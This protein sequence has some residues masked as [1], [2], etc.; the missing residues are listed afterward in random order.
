MD[1]S[2]DTEQRLREYL[3]RATVDLRQAR[4]RLAEA[5]DRAGEPI[6]IVGMACR[7][8]GGVRSPEDL[9]RL[10]AAGGDATSEFPT[11][12]GW[13]PDLH[14]PDPDRAGHTYTTRGGFLDDV[15]RFDAE[16]FGISPREALAMDP[17]QRQLLEVSW[18]A[19]ERA[20]IDPLSLRGTPTG[21][22]A[23]AMVQDYAS[24][25]AVPP[26]GF[27]GYLGNGNSGAMASGRVA[28]TLGLEGPAVTLDTACSSSLVAVHLAAQALRQGEC[29]L[30]LT[31]G[32]TVMSTPALF[33]EF[34]RQRGLAPDGRCKPFSAGADGTGWAEGVGVLVLER[35]SEARRHGRR[36]LAVVRGSAVNSDGA[37]SGLTAPNGPSQQRVI[38][39]ALTVAG[40]SPSDVDVVE[41]H[42]T[43][44]TLGD[45]IE[46]QALLATYGQDRDRPLLLG[47]V[48]ANL[49]HTQ[50]AAG[51]AGIIK[52][53]MAMRHGVVPPT[54]HL[55]EPTPRVDWSEGAVSLVTEALPWP[56]RDAP[57]RAGVSAFGASGTNAHLVLEQAPPADALDPPAGAAV[58]PWPLSGHTPEALRAQAAGLAGVTADPAEI[59]LALATAR[60]ALE[61]R[62][63]LVAGPDQR[64]NALAALAD[65]LPHPDV[66]TGQAPGDPRE[67]VFVFPGQGSQWVGM[68]VDLLD[69]PVFAAR[70]DECATALSSYVDWDL[71]EV[72]R[73]ESALARVDVVQP[74]LWAVMVSLAAVWRHHGVKPAAVVGHSQGEIAAACVAG[75]LSLEDGA[76]V[77]ALR[78][79][80]LARIAGR[81]GMVSV[82]LPVGEVDLSGGLS[83]AA[84]NGPG[85]TVVSGPPAALAAVLDRYERA[86]RVPVDYASHSVQVA[87]LREEL[88]TALA[89]V[90]PRPGQIPFH[91]TVTGARESRLDAEYWYRNLRETVRFADVT[92]ELAAH[93][94]AFVEV[95]PHPVLTVGLQETVD[96]A[97][98]DAVVLGTLRRDEPG[99]RRLLASFAEA[100]TR[101]VPVDWRPAFSGARPA[102]LPTYPFGGDRY[103]LTEGPARGVLDR[104]EDLADGGL[105]LSGTLTH[106]THP[107]LPDHAVD[108]TVL[109]P[110]TGMLELAAAA[111]DRVG[112]PRVEE[113]AL[114]APLPVPAEA[115]VTL[116]VTVGGADDAGRRSLR[117]HARPSPDDPWTRHATGTLAPQAGAPAPAPAEWPP[118][119]AEPV[120]LDGLYERLADGGLGYGPAFRGLR[121]AWRHDDWVLA[122]VALPDGL[123]P[124]GFLLHPALVDA[125]LQAVGLGG[126]LDQPDV[127]L[128]P[129]AI[130]GAAVHATGATALR[131]MVTAAGR[132]AVRLAL[133]DTAGRAVAT[134]DSLVLR[135]MPRTTAAWR[136][137]LY[138]VDW[139]PAAPGSGEVPPHEVVECGS[140]H[141]ALTLLR[142]RLADPDATGPLVVLT[143]GAVAARPA[144]LPDLAAAAVW[145]LVRSAQTENPGR[146]VLVDLEAGTDPAEPVARV[147][148]ADEPQVAVRDG[149]MFVP[150]LSRARDL[151]VVEPG[152]RLAAGAGGSLDDLHLVPSGEVEP[153]PGQVRLDVRA[154][155][156]NFRDVLIALDLYPGEPVLGA[157][158]AG[159]VTAVGQGVVDLAPGDRVFGLVPG[160]FARSAVVD[161]RLLAR[162][163]RDWTFAEAASVPVVFLSAYYALRD[164]ADLRAGETVLVHAA[165]GGVGMAATQLAR[166]LG[167]HVLGTASPAKWAATGLDETC[168]ASSREP[169][170]AD[171]FRGLVGERGVDVVLNSLT[172][173]F[174]DESL[175]LLAA[176]GR[177]VELGRT[178]LRDPADLPDVRYRAFELFEA[179]PDRIAEMLTELL[180]LFERGVL[181]PLP[182]RTWD[183]GRGREALRHL[184]QGENVGK[185]VLTVPAPLDPDGTVLVTGGTGTLGGLLARHLV[186]AHGC[187]HLLLT[188]L[189]GR[190]GTDLAGE[191]TALGARVR[192]RRCDV[193]DRDAL[194]ALVASVPAEHPLTAVVHTAG[195][196]DDGVLET[197]TPAHLDRV[198]A[199]KA[200][201]AEHLAELTRDHDLAAFVLFSSAAATMG[202]A[203]QGNYAAANAVLDALALRLRAAGRPATAVAWGLWEP[204]S[205]MT[206]GLDATDRERMRRAGAAPLSTADGM[207]LFD[208][209]LAVAEP[210]LVATRIDLSAVRARAAT[211]GVPAL[212][213]GLVPVRGERRT[214]GSATGGL[215]ALPPAELA[216]ALTDLVRTHVAATLGHG[217]PD[218][219]P[220]RK[221][222]REQGF[223]SLTA[224]ELRNR[225]GAATG[226][227]LPATLVFDHPT[228]T[229]L[230][231]HLT[232]ELTGAAADAGAPTPA[233]AADDD[234]IAIV[235]LSCRFPGGVGTP[236]EL[237]RLLAD[238]GDAIGPFPTDRGW[239]PDPRATV[240]AGGFLPD[241]ALFDAGFFGIAPREA[242][243]SDPQQRL[244]LEAS[245]E[246]LER[247]GID[248]ATLR[249]TRTGVYV[250]AAY[251]DYG[252]GMFDAEEDL[253]GY[254][255]TGN[256]G[257]VVSGRISYTFGF[258]GPSVTVD[259]ACSSSL[260]ALH[261]AVRALRAGECSLA[262]AGG[263]TVMATPNSFV[264]FGRQGGMAPDGRCKAF[265]AAADGF[266]AAE[267]LGLVLVERLSDARANGHPVLALVRGSAVNSDGASNGLTAPNGPSQRRVIQL[268]LADA[269]L[270]PSD[271]DAVEAHGTGTTLGDPIEAGALL[272]TYGTDRER[273][274]WLGSVK[275]N[276]G[277]S[278]FA[279]GVAGVLKVVLALRNGLL[280]RT[281]HV[282]EPSPHVDWSAGE[283]RLLTAPVPWPAGERPRRAGVSSF[284]IS[285]T[286]AHVLLEQA[287]ADPPADPPTAQAG[288]PV[289][290][291]FSAATPAALRE[292]A[293]R[294]ADHVEADEGLGPA[295]VGHSLVSTRAALPHRAAVVA[296]DR[297]GLL[298]GLRSFAADG[299]GALAGVAGADADRV[300]F[301]FAGQGGQWPGMAADL[302]ATSPAFAAEFDACA[303]AI[304]ALVDFSPLAVLRGEPG[305][306][307]LDRIEVLQPVLFAV[308]VSLA[309]LWRAHG[310]EPAAVVGQSQGEVAA[311]YVAGALSLRDAVAV[312]VLRSR[313]FAEELV[314]RGAIASVL[315][316][317]EQV[318]ERIVPWAGRV[319]V[320]GTSGPRSATVS[321]E[322]DALAEL[323]AACTADGIRARVLPATVA[324]HGAQVDPL[325]ERLLASLA[326]VRPRPESIPFYSTVTGD[327]VDPAELDAGYWFRN[328]REPVNLDAAVR[329]LIRD[330][331]R[332]FVEP[333]PHPAATLSVEQI[334]EDARSGTDDHAVRAVATLHRD[335]P[336]PERFAAALAQAYAHGVPVEWSAV[337]P[338]ARRVPLPTYPFQRRRYWVVP[339]RGTG[340]LRAA[341]LAEAAHPLLSAAAGRA[342][343][344]L[345]LTGRLGERDWLAGER[346]HRTLVVP[347]AVLLDL[348]L[349]A[350][351]RV[352]CQVAEL[353]VGE[354][355]VHR[356]EPVVEV[357]VGAPGEDGSRRLTVHTR[358]DDEP[359]TCHA[360]AVLTPEGPLAA[361]APAQWP[362]TGARPVDV[363]AHYA[364]LAAAGV[365]HGP[366]FRALRAAWAHDGET[367]AELRL[368]DD[369]PAGAFALHP[370]LLDAVLHALPADPARTPAAWRGVGVH[371]GEAGGVLRV[372]L[373]PAPDGTVAVAVTDTAGSPVLTVEAVTTAE[374]AV[375]RLRAAGLRDQLVVPELVPAPPA[376][377]VSDWLLVGDAPA[378][379]PRVGGASGSAAVVLAVAAPDEVPVLLCE[380]EESRLVVVTE[381][382]ARGLVLAA[383]AERPGRVQLLDL[384][385]SPASA[386]ALPAALASTEPHLVLRDGAVLVPRLTRPAL[387]DPRPVAAALVTGG[388][389]A[390]RLA[391]HLAARDED[392]DG[393]V[394][395]VADE[396]GEDD[397]LTAARAEV[398]A[399]DNAAERATG[400]L[401]LCGP[402]GPGAAASA[403]RA[404]F[405]RIAER[406]HAAGL[407]T[408][409]LTVDRE[410]DEDLG[411]LLDLALTAGAPTVACLAHEPPAP[412]ESRADDLP[413]AARLAALAEPDRFALVL[414]LVRARA[415]GVLGHD[416]ATELDDSRALRE[417]GFD[418]MSAVV[419]RDR[420]NRATGLRLPATTAF[421]HP[422]VRAL[423]AHLLRE[424]LG[425]PEEH[426][427]AAAAART[428][429]PIAIVAMACRFPGGVRAPE[430]LW[431][432]VAS[433]TDAITPFPTDRGWD[434]EAVY[435]PEPGRP[436]RTYVRSGGFLDEVAGFDAEFFG[437][438]PREAVAMDPQQR[439]LLQSAWEVF[440]RAGLDPTALRGEQVGVFAGTS[441]QDYTGALLAAGAED[442]EA[443]GEDGT[444][445]VITG[446][447]ASVL[448]GRLAYAF[449][450]EGPAVT[451][452][453]A[454]S[455]SLVAVH[456]AAQS[457]R[458]GECSLAVAGAA[459]VMATPAAFVAFSRQ[460]GLAPDG[461]CKAFSAAADG[462]AWAEG[463]GTLL[464]ERLSDARANGHPVLAVLRGSAVNSDGASNG[465]AAPNGRAQQRVIHTALAVAGL[466]PSDVDAVEAHGTGTRL[467][468]PIEATALLA[469][470]G[471]ERDRPLWL[472]SVKSNI[473]HT[474]GVSGIAGVVKTVLS[475]RHGLLPRTLHVDEPTPQVDWSAGAVRLLTED[476]PWP[477]NGRP[478]RAGVSSFGV[479]GT[480]AHVVLEEVDQPLP[481]PVEPGPGPVAWPLSA[482]TPD[483]LAATAEALLS[484]VDGLR[485]ADVAHTLTAG[486][487]VFGTRAVV[488]GADPAGLAALAAGEPHPAVVRGTA[489]RPGPL[490]VLFAG[491]GAQRVG[492]GRGLYSAFGAFA[493]AFD[494]LCDELSGHLGTS[495]R[496]AVFDGP[497]EALRGTALAQAALFA[498]EAATAELLRSFGVRPDYLLGHS[499]GE[500]AAVHAAG[501]LSTEDACALVAARGRL[502]AAL[503]AG[504]AMLAVQATETE[505]VDSINGH[506]VS[507]AAVN[508]PESVV[509]SGDVVGVAALAEQWRARSRRTRLLEVSHAFHSA[510]VEP[511]L[512]ELAEVAAGLT[513]HEPLV[514]IVSTLTGRLAGPELTS[515]GYWP[516]QARSPVRFLDA[517]RTLVG[518]GVRTFL[519]A[520]PDGTLAAAAREAVGPEGGGE[521]VPCLR[522]DRPEPEALTAALARLHVTGRAVDWA[523]FHAPHRPR[524]VDLPTYPF[525]TR[526]F[527]LRVA[528]GAPAER[529]TGGDLLS[530]VR[531]EAA[532]VL[533][534]GSRADVPAD[535]G[536][537]ELGFD[538]LT[539]AELTSRLAAAVGRPVPTV[540]VF[541]HPTP[542][543]LAEHLGALADERDEPASGPEPTV[544]GPFQAMFTRA[545]ESSRTGEFMDFLD[546]ASR[547]RTEF[548]DPAGVGAEPVTITSGPA[549]RTALVCLPGFIGMPGPQQ[550]TR[551]AAP[552]RA[553]REVTVLRHPG[554]APGE[555]VP[556]DPGVLIRLHAEWIER[557]H[558]D[559]PFALVGLSSGGLVAQAVA[560]HLERA[561]VRPEGVVL[562]D[563]FGP[564]LDH[565]VDVLLPEFAVRL[566]D[567]HVAMGYGAADDWL[568]AMGRYVGFDWRVE[569]LTT[570]VLFLRASEPM[571]EWTHEGDWR[572]SWPGARSV[573][574]VPGDHFSMMGDYAEHT[575]AAV[576][577]WLG[578]DVG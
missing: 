547:F 255:V 203:G 87:E 166:H 295:D 150:R 178:D 327:R 353:T 176:G 531:A 355:L 38:R 479:S 215:A 280:P 37:S 389:R 577:R 500:L 135:P 132:D 180:A 490:A 184:R 541:D 138:R 453:T 513:F 393:V 13:D 474:Q 133:F 171:A 457:L 533:G 391:E 335:E 77:V 488:V 204:R 528:E 169:G 523:A 27:E 551:F 511:V 194:A 75:V 298:A 63:V 542:A 79:R 450:F 84:V 471:A 512:T 155:G 322:Q 354:P 362:P 461:R 396:P 228:P 466:Q 239:D 165:A 300:V 156:L 400:Q 418:S 463:V 555:P 238:G 44:T 211:D 553:E 247:A 372:R 467:G 436:G 366:A 505:V 250:G 214:A 220:D 54:P 383:A 494:E 252:T 148:A 12:R 205:G 56:E 568:T 66:V 129:F 241:A 217:S 517:V 124:E 522:A 394:V 574:D 253:T 114:L 147:L 409:S 222:F 339:G 411:P 197:L 112:C 190:D 348:A 364:A 115:T 535:R 131:V 407:P 74:A 196:L 260:V 370:V 110:G 359:W 182:L 236:E 51:V 144:E 170:F 414:D 192:V 388:T 67:A 367:Y 149:A 14:D 23:G 470:Y 91:S 440:E 123:S 282:D 572:T 384:D 550:F 510:A 284:G 232:A 447:S 345:L 47:A 105:L 137:A 475:M 381:D 186:T 283:V 251:N 287:P 307:G 419:L 442:A 52:L 540:A 102:D 122:E 108:G 434:V 333:S 65:G 242:L 430:D 261:L 227:R 439:L 28:Y 57:R 98:A 378:L 316:P 233:R 357:S 552:F 382:P 405:D 395:H 456:L 257:S 350:A 303:D 377:P 266:G 387:G 446:G 187:R 481:P 154:A 564:H 210:T 539:A 302:Y 42:G 145:G 351:H 3:K 534:H 128:L 506:A 420:L 334:A 429:E 545:I 508:G 64:A 437:I 469:T 285:G 81:G 301:V 363:A 33:L 397:P 536:F 524:H 473:G 235:A 356:G 193:S 11:D 175:R 245:W 515:P 82:P 92:T 226:L 375:A 221:P 113:L 380:H 212:L 29:G 321:G 454:C 277:H 565:L 571:I 118:A 30:A 288:G 246:L 451:V 304:A 365:E 271:V 141:H 557:H 309:A 299:S 140:V 549:D 478:R 562:L 161:R 325:R 273:P 55:T 275:S 315:L 26:E 83:V 399:A 570:P 368:P 263:V 485:P 219:V 567:A 294:L 578:K 406:R 201:A 256:S 340:D 60:A 172:G 97:G 532:A 174:V 369:A 390:A 344:G 229:A 527:W 259:T 267:G 6:A 183:L 189:S 424:L 546:A 520:G 314:G 93:G 413:L 376:P 293:A 134:V 160:A 495:L 106:R 111:G 563:T 206:A 18:E 422:T 558:G 88:L 575:A 458:S 185:V 49:G 497:A 100:H 218:A 104:V 324:S 319:D 401:V 90:S 86:R 331:H 269:G 320:A 507:L 237:W 281:L 151:L 125:A 70:F 347:A 62:A 426:T 168:L 36:V 415:A 89:P 342:D 279:A 202:S 412:P 73:D 244:L 45:P 352:G 199:P 69:H 544:N 254:V 516:E 502:M 518:Q 120:V 249:G 538:S 313:L 85:S 514:P 58:V 258:E 371:D 480:N 292:V 146:F 477:R 360:T 501:V 484:S 548:T 403:V 24:R 41:A 459:A 16:L 493:T 554:F 504:G 264:E 556:A 216:R 392:Q 336:G 1:T 427:P 569:E 408:L 332:V 80:A 78:S 181:A 328:C 431:R 317:V 444:D 130:T 306:P 361:A 262:L 153:G 343:G 576:A 142:E 119:G 8:P 476:V 230:V 483:A 543:A 225:L 34:S 2:Q 224:V 312:V 15:G 296:A 207:A 346:L 68:A 330:G 358:E 445:Y 310:V 573:T 22:F 498:V 209:A 139:V 94:P 460:R 486:R 286:N 291:P 107:W 71:R 308:V 179:G 173:P 482:R 487:A 443:G 21:V 10:V 213:R 465:L 248:P 404:A 9:W 491:Q 59:G 499:V 560:G 423:A 276:L 99:P 274:L 435:D 191:L 559:R 379:A 101:G 489:V 410:L 385:D 318:R 116:Q 4:R 272:E 496:A 126:F 96:A 428:D 48:K 117:V 425:E 46:A 19:V 464:L 373:T 462:T 441:G 200:D 417:L 20:G 311:A 338:G 341:G 349:Y 503:P 195:A 416:D 529:E 530:V 95:S 329:A 398:L 25:F 223:D 326:G 305:A 162:V 455:S 448:S 127:P 492:M 290:V 402:S 386:R 198:F 157:E 452:D 289:P 433:G 164:L 525:R 5:E 39:R 159:V 177:F 240:R 143:R 521:F 136:D 270:Q 265:A 438:S 7:Y 109:F 121:A 449:G 61:H 163:P 374:P 297:A 72:L 323:V 432:L 243:A 537:L 53:A 35:L 40:L 32:V 468:D 208:A 188:S 167:A 519:D 103:W 43:G 152:S 17:Q 278:Q 76:R 421:D 561:G 526:R 472:G 231:T 158:A 337:Y 566:H 50:A 268:A 31:G 234:P 509:V